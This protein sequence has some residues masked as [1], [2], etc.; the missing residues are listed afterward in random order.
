MPDF[1]IGSVIIC[2][3]ARKEISG[4]D[5]LIG[6]YGGGINTPL[7]PININLCFWFELVPKRIG[8]IAIEL[9]VECPGTTNPTL[10]SI[11]ADV[12]RHGDTFGIFT[13]QIN[14][15][16]GQGG[17]IKLYMR[18]TGKDSWKLLKRVP[19]NYLSSP[20]PSA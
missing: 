15:A 12:K 8:E 14:Y 16:I 19:V 1:T 7:L 6:V 2:E 20:V 5:I 3:D 11:K 18:A 17:D 10:L 13:P 4:K 9:K